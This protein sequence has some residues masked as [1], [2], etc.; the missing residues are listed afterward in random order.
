MSPCSN[1]PI[2]N[3]KHSLM[4]YLT[5]G[6]VAQFPNSEELD[7]YINLFSFFICN[8]DTDYLY[9]LPFLREQHHK[10]RS[11]L[12]LATQKYSSLAVLATEVISIPVIK[13]L[14]EDP[15]HCKSAFHLSINDFLCVDLRMPDNVTFH[16]HFSF[17]GAICHQNRFTFKFDNFVYSWHE[18]DKN[19]T[20]VSDKLTPL[21]LELYYGGEK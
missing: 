5:D 19:I 15:T 12:H 6:G 4:Q 11:F 16:E 20:E 14:L 3:Y 2:E 10:F 7:C 17:I 9:N 18:N 8:S 21:I 1:N 13:R